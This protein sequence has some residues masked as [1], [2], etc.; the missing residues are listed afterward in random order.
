MYTNR[1]F[2][3]IDDC[4]LL[5]SLDLFWS[6]F[7]WINALRTS[8]LMH[9][10]QVIRP[11]LHTGST[12]PMF[13]SHQ[14]SM[15]VH[16]YRYS[17]ELNPS[18]RHGRRV[19]ALRCSARITRYSLCK[20]HSQ[21]HQVVPDG[22]EKRHDNSSRT[23]LNNSGFLV[24]CRWSYLSQFFICLNIPAQWTPKPWWMKPPWSWLPT[25]IASDQEKRK[26]K[27]ISTKMNSQCWKT[28][29]LFKIRGV[30]GS[31]RWLNMQLINFSTAPTSLSQ[32]GFPKKT[33]LYRF[34]EKDYSG[35]INIWQKT[36]LTH[37]LVFCP[38]P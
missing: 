3:V 31:F 17:K 12:R 18:T 33:C 38:I 15:V 14:E 27:C 34:P 21:Q 6:L 4:L 25:G 37:K 28:L 20:C 23:P 13:R 24:I 1:I 16:V 7:P 26:A 8:I 22:F 36:I 35:V 29:A 9:K 2:P 30:K 11:V 5:P 19:L 32:G 10:P